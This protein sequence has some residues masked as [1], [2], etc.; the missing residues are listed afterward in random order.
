MHAR[1]H[2][3]LLT[4]TLPLS[5]PYAGEMIGG[6]A[7]VLVGHLRGRQ[8]SSAYW[9]HDAKGA[10]GHHE[11]RVSDTDAS[12]RLHDARCASKLSAGVSFKGEHAGGTRGG[13]ED[14][15][16][17]GVR[18]GCA[19]PLHHMSILHHG[20]GMHV[21]AS[22]CTCDSPSPSPPPPSALDQHEETQE[23]EMQWL[24]SIVEVRYTT[25]SLQHTA[26]A[27]AAPTQ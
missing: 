14:R 18:G 13:G 4:H 10:A 12:A 24:I 27:R 20:L 21:G 8:K 16:T 25:P 15:R 2:V 6:R 5:Q 9:G 3:S 7:R 22:A 23:K 1:M 11:S 26:H 17:A 19:S